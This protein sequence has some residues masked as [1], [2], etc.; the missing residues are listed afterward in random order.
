MRRLRLDDVLVVAPYNAQVG[1]PTPDAPAAGQATPLDYMPLRL[2]PH[3]SHA[4]T[5]C[6]SGCNHMPPHIAPRL[7]VS[8]LLQ[9]ELPSYHPLQ[10]RLLESM[11]PRGARVGTV[12]RF[13][14]SKRA[15]SK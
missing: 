15:R 12:D 1:R 3:V 11:L 14:V 13:Q 2:Q 9:P 5:T 7:L 4:A 6:P 10:V 8:V